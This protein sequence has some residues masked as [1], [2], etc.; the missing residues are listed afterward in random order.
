[1]NTKVPW[2]NEQV[3]DLANVESVNNENLQSVIYV[4]SIYLSIYY[5]PDDLLVLKQMFTN[6]SLYFLL[7]AQSSTE[8]F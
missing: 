3:G 7:L 4:L 2:V 5:L 6:K 8:D 1:M